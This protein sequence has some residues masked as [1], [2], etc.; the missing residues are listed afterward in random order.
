[1]IAYPWPYI[2]FPV[3]RKCKC[4]CILRKPIERK[5]FYSSTN[6]KNSI[7]ANTRGAIKPKA[8]ARLRIRELELP[9]LLLLEDIFPSVQNL[10]NMHSHKKIP[11]SIRGF[12]SAAEESA[13]DDKCAICYLELRGPVLQ[14]PCGHRF[15]IECM[16]R[17]DRFWMS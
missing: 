4:Q 11:S 2:C 6:R 14:T 5:R 1:M 8:V 7:V 13:N 17:Y 15:C 10:W 9:T 16:M 12:N 3:R